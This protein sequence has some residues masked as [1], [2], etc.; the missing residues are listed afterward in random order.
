MAWAGKLPWGAARSHSICKHVIRNTVA[1][2]PLIGVPAPVH[3][4]QV[5]PSN[6]A[7][8][9]GVCEE[10]A[11]RGGAPHLDD[12]NVRPVP[13]GMADVFGPRGALLD[14]GLVQE[15]RRG[16]TIDREVRQMEDEPGAD[17]FA[18]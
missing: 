8:S 6:R 2:A 5:E 1:V 12:E 10:S 17:A 16:G 11:D 18:A 3:V 9:A 14:E 7:K 13:D 4:G 15:V